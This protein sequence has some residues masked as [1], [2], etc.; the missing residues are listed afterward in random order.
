VTHHADQNALPGHEG[1]VVQLQLLDES[2]GGALQRDV[3]GR[4]NDTDVRGFLGAELV[5]L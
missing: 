5:L 3:G 2:F 1:A 4:D